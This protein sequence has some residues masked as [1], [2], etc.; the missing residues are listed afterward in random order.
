MDFNTYQFLKKLKEYPPEKLKNASIY[1]TFD[2]NKSYDENLKNQNDFFIK[3]FDI[4][5]EKG[6]TFTLK[7]NNISRFRFNLKRFVK[8]F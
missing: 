8:F 7:T 6:V 5:S 3:A 4:F 2:C 1:Y